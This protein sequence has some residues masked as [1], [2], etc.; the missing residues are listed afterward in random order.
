MAE[1]ARRAYPRQETKAERV[2]ALR[3][4]TASLRRD[5]EE[6]GYRPLGDGRARDAA[7]R[8]Q[9]Q[10]QPPAA[11]HAAAELHAAAAAP[12]S[13]FRRKSS[14]KN[15]LSKSLKLT[16]DHK[17]VKRPEDLAAAAA[18]RELSRTGPSNHP[19]TARLL[20]QQTATTGSRQ[21]AAAEEP[22]VKRSLPTLSLTR[23]DSHQPPFDPS[24]AFSPSHAGQ[25]DTHHKRV[26]PK[27]PSTTTIVP[28]TPRHIEVDNSFG[29]LHALRDAVPDSVHVDDVADPMSPFHFFNSLKKPADYRFCYGVRA[30]DDDPYHIELAAHQTDVQ[31][32]SSNKLY[33]TLSGSGVTQTG[34]A[35]GETSFTPLQEW[36]GEYKAFKVIASM[37]FFARYRQWSVFKHWKHMVRQTS[38]EAAKEALQANHL[39]LHPMFADPLKKVQTLCATCREQALIPVPTHTASLSHYVQQLS[40]RRKAIDDDF[41]AAF[42]EV[43]DTVLGSCREVSNTLALVRLKEAE[44]GSKDKSANYID[45]KHSEQRANATKK[46]RLATLRDL[47][48]GGE[49]RT[50]TPPALPPGAA[51]MSADS[52][53]QGRGVVHKM[54]SFL[55]LVDNMVHDALLDFAL[56]AIAGFGELVKEPG[57]DRNV[58]LCLKMLVAS[59]IVPQSTVIASRFRLRSNAPPAASAPVGKKTPSFRREPAA[60]PP[61]AA[62]PAAPAKKQAGPPAAHAAGKPNRAFQASDETSLHRTAAG[63]PV[64]AYAHVFLHPPSHLG[65]TELFQLDVSVDKSAPADFVITPGAEDFNSLVDLVVES[66]AKLCMQYQPFS[67]NEQF[68]QYTSPKESLRAAAD[69]DDESNSARSTNRDDSDDDSSTQAPSAVRVITKAPAFQRTVET[70]KARLAAAVRRAGEATGTLGPYKKLY[71][72][73]MSLVPGEIRDSDPPLEWFERAFQRMKTQEK[74]LDSMPPVMRVDIFTLNTAPL[75]AVVGPSP[76]ECMAML[77]RLLPSIFRE[78]NKKL[79]DK[80][81]TTSE[82]L[83]AP[84]DSLEAL[85]SLLRN[86]AD[87]G[88]KWPAVERRFDD[89]TAYAGFLETEDIEWAPE[90]RAFWTH[91]T[92]PVMA[93]LR[94][95]LIEVERKKDAAIVEYATVIDE[96]LKE[97]EVELLEVESRANDPAF[98]DDEADPDRAVAELDQILKDAERIRDRERLLCQYQE[99]FNLDVAHINQIAT[100]HKAANDRHKLWSSMRNWVALTQQWSETPYATIRVQEIADAAS[101]Y[102][103]YVNHLTRSLP[104]FPALLKLRTMVDEV[105]LVLPVVAALTNPA[106]HSHHKANVASIVGK[107]LSDPAC[108]L[109]DLIALRVTDLKE[110]VKSVSHAATQESSLA[111]QLAQLIRQWQ[112]HEFTLLSHKSVSQDGAPAGGSADTPTSLPSSPTSI[113]GSFAFSSSKETYIITNADP[114]FAA[115]DDAVASLSTIANSRYCVV[116]LHG[117]ATR[118]IHDLKQASATVDKWL[119]C[120]RKWLSLEAIYSNPD[121]C[122]QW[123]GEAKAFATVDRGM[124]DRMRAVAAAPYVMRAVLQSESFS[125]LDRIL[126]CLEKLDRELARN[127]N[128]KRA[129]F[130]RLHFLSD[131]DLIDIISRAKIP[132]DVS[133]HLP[134]L[135]GN[136]SSL[137]ADDSVVTGVR[138]CEGETLMLLKPIRARKEADKWLDRLEESIHGTLRKKARDAVASLLSAASLETWIDTAHEEYP[139]QMILA[140]HNVRFCH[141]VESE[142]EHAPGSGGRLHDSDGQG[143][144]ADGQEAGESGA[145]APP[146]QARDPSL[147]LRKRFELLSKAFRRE[148]DV[149]AD[150]LAGNPERTAG[151]VHSNSPEA[152]RMHSGSFPQ[153]ASNLLPAR[154]FPM[155]PLVPRNASRTPTTP[156][157]GGGNPSAAPLNTLARQSLL[158]Q[159]TAQTVHHRDIIEH[160]IASKSAA[161]AEFPWA[162]QLRA[163]YSGTATSRDLLLRQVGC[164]YAYGYEF[165]GSA[166]RLVATPLTDRIFLTISSALAQRLGALAAGPAGTGKTETIRDLARH[167]GRR[168]VVYNCSGAVTSRTVEKLLAGLCQ[169]GAWGCLDELNRVPF[170]VLSAMAHHFSA[171]RQALVAGE[172]LVEIAGDTIPIKPSFALLATM[173]TGYNARTEL[174]GNVKVLFRPVAALKTDS[175]VIARVMLHSAGFSDAEVVADRLTR[176]FEACADLLG[177]RPHYAFGLRELKMVLTAASIA[178]NDPSVTDKEDTI[179]VRCCMEGIVPRLDP[180]DSEL[181]KDVIKNLF[182]DAHLSVHSPVS[183]SIKRA[184]VNELKHEQWHEKTALEKC[185]HLHSV[186]SLRT[187]IILLGPPGSGKTVCRATLFAAINCNP[188]DMPTLTIRNAAPS[189]SILVPSPAPRPLSPSALYSTPAPRLVQAVLNPRS[190]SYNEVYGYLDPLSHTWHPGVVSQLLDE[191]ARSECESW[192]VF[193]GGVTSAWIET[194]NTVLDDTKA[195]S[196]ASGLPIRVKPEDKFLFEVD[197]VANASPATITRCCVVSFGAVSPEVTINAWSNRVLQVLVPFPTMVARASGLLTKHA[198]RALRFVER[199]A[200]AK[201][202]RASTSGVVQS[203]LS[204]FEAVAAAEDLSKHVAQGTAQRRP[205]V[206]DRTGEIVDL[207]ACY[208]LLWGVLGYLD[209]AGQEKWDEALREDLATSLV[210][211]AGPLVDQCLDLSAVRFVAW[212]ERLP[213]Y[214]PE[215]VDSVDRRKHVSLRMSVPVVDSVKHAHVIR[216]LALSGKPCL[217]SGPAGVGKT[218]ITQDALRDTGRVVPVLCSEATDA[219]RIRAVLERNLTARGDAGV[220]SASLGADFFSLSKPDGVLRPVTGQALMFL[221]DDVNLAS[222][223]GAA[224]CPFEFLRQVAETASFHTAKL[225]KKRVTGLSITACA[226]SEPSTTGLL[227]A[228]TLRHFVP[229]FIPHM[230]DDS[231]QAIT[232]TLLTTFFTHAEFSREILDLV[233]PFAQGSA[234]V[235]A[236]MQ[237]SIPPCY[238]TP[239]Y[240]FSLRS[241]KTVVQGM[242]FASAATCSTP[243][244]A[245]QLWIH[246][247]SRCF[248][249]CLLLDEHR[250]TFKTTLKGALRRVFPPEAWEGD[251]AALDAAWPVMWGDFLRPEAFG[252][253]RVY[254]AVAE[255]DKLPELFD[256]YTAD[257]FDT[258]MRLVF[259]K[260]CCVHLTRVLRML[261]FSGTHSLLLGPAFSGRQTLVRLAATMREYECFSLAAH[262]LYT[263]DNFLVDLLQIHDAA[264]LHSRD[265]VLLLADSQLHIPGVMQEINHLL[266]GYAVPNL[267]SAE[268]ESK[269]VNAIRAEG[270]QR[271]WAD[272]TFDE[273]LACYRTRARE[274]IHVVLCATPGGNFSKLCR[275]FPALTTCCQVDVVEPWPRA[276]LATIAEKLLPEEEPDL[277]GLSQKCARVHELAAHAAAAAGAANAVPVEVTP[278][279][280]FDFLSM[281]AQ[282]YADAAH[283]LESQQA[284]LAKGA[285]MMAETERVVEKM[286]ASLTAAT[287]DLRGCHEKVAAVVVETESVQAKL[288][289][290]QAETAAKEAVAAR[291]RESAEAL[292]ASAETELATVIP[293]INAAVK[294]LDALSK[295]DIIEIRSYAQPPPVVSLVTQAVLILLQETNPA[296][297]AQAKHVMNQPTFLDRLKNFDKDQIPPEASARLSPILHEREFNPENVGQTGSFA[298]KSLCLWVTAMHAYNAARIKMAPKRAAL[299]EAECILED[300]EE[301]FERAS[302]ALQAVTGELDAL[303]EIRQRAQSEKRDCEEKIGTARKRLATADVL[304]AALSDQAAAWGREAAGLG[305]RLRAA[306]KHAFLAS[307]F[308]SYAGAFNPSRR[309]GLISAWHALYDE[310]TIPRPT[311]EAAPEGHPGGPPATDARL[312]DFLSCLAGHGAVREWVVSSLPDDPVSVENALLAWNCCTER[313]NRWPL[314]VDPQEQACGWLSKLLCKDGLVTLR[315]P[316]AEAC[317]SVSVASTFAPKQQQHGGGGGSPLAGSMLL[318]SSMSPRLKSANSGILNG[319]EQPDD[320][321]AAAATS[322]TPKM[323][324]AAVP[325]PVARKPRDSRPDPGPSSRKAKAVTAFR[326]AVDHAMERGDPLLITRADSAIDPYLTPILQKKYTESYFG[327]GLCHIVLGP[328]R[329]LPYKPSFK[330]FLATDSPSTIGLPT[331]AWALCNVVNFSVTAEALEAQLLSQF[332]ATERPKW[333]EARLSA[334]SVI[335]SSKKLT[336]SYEDQTLA[337]LDKCAAGD[338]LD[339]AS[340][341]KNLQKIRQTAAFVERQIVTSDERAA[342]AQKE[343]ERYTPVARRAASL[344]FL[345]N[346]L[347]ALDPMYQYSIAAV[348]RVCCATVRARRAS[349]D[350]DQ[351]PPLDDAHVASLVTSVTS[352]VHAYISLGL[353]AAHRAAFTLCMAASTQLKEQLLAPSDWKLLF[354]PPSQATREALA[355]KLSTDI[356]FWMDTVTWQ[357]LAVLQAFDSRGNLANLSEHVSQQSVRWQKWLQSE[358]PFREQAPLPGVTDF[359]AL[360]LLLCFRPELGYAHTECYAKRVL[361]EDFASAKE[362]AA[363]VGGVLGAGPDGGESVVLFITSRDGDPYQEVLRAAKARNLRAGQVHKVSCGQGQDAALKSAWEVCKATGDWLYLENAHIAPQELLYDMVQSAQ[364]FPGVKDT[365]TPGTPRATANA[366]G[367]GFKLFLTAP[368]AGGVSPSVI[369]AA[370][371]VQRET[372]TAVRATMVRALAVEAAEVPAFFAATAQAATKAL[373]YS[374]CSLHAALLDRRRYGAQGW[375]GA[376]D[377]DDGDLR[378]ALEWIRSEAPASDIFRHTAAPDS[379][380]KEADLCGLVT[381]VSDVFYGGKLTDPWDQR[382]LGCL[383]RRFL[384]GGLEPRRPYCSVAAYSIPEGEG[385][386]DFVY[387][388]RRLPAEDAPEFSGMHPSAREARAR[389]ETDELLADALALERHMDFVPGALRRRSTLAGRR[390]SAPPPSPGLPPQPKAAGP[391]PS[392]GDDQED[393]VAALVKAVLDCLPAPI[394]F[395]EGLHPNALQREE[396]FAVKHVLKREVERY[397]ALIDTVF[398]DT[399]VLSQA[400]RGEAL[401][402]P[403]V[404]EL[405]EDFYANRVP[406]GWQAAAC[407]SLKPLADWAHDLALKV[408]FVGGWL[409]K[410][411]PDYYWLGALFSPAALRAV[412]AQQFA[413]HRRVSVADVTFTYA[414]GAAAPSLATPA[415]ERKKTVFFEAGD[416]SLRRQPSAPSRSPSGNSLQNRIGVK[417]VLLSGLYCD[418]CG[419]NVENSHLT[420]PL[421]KTRY[422][423]LPLILMRPGLKGAKAGAAL[424]LSPATRSL[425]EDAERAEKGTIDLELPVFRHRGRY[426]AGPEGARRSTFVF[427]VVLPCLEVYPLLTSSFSR[428]RRELGNKRSDG[429]L[430]VH[431]STPADDIIQYGAAIL[432]QID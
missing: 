143:L 146:A 392:P 5:A 367:L 85:A 165:L 393:R 357:K 406:A 29:W 156:L 248:S 258:R 268:E 15:G 174:P 255:P 225:A 416:S 343:R 375:S 211:A 173:N 44:G 230:S 342:A 421:P 198:V 56:D 61:A 422:Q 355:A 337:E 176:L 424:V 350:D 264:G 158:F 162:K 307:A 382:V 206:D 224:P 412:V 125:H 386:S 431:E 388:A 289:S 283:S 320:P 127:L 425:G 261:K 220:P 302:T 234:E 304:R 371:K 89:L 411:D 199:E 301:E 55:K 87:A 160:L 241:I 121:I 401:E 423:A 429:T 152:G 186:L 265:I 78:K 235:L 227:P 18:E 45:Y 274:K 428:K 202:A 281:Y 333:E 251:C 276:A 59:N 58:E 124:R 107:D 66:T 68:L 33:Y 365:K 37:P 98:A 285:G 397:N 293:D 236:T 11:A 326:Q 38:M 57:D 105:K 187:G 346:H 272:L 13:P 193:D 83:N 226:L 257:L 389:S 335:A 332:V 48:S 239:H 228:R 414:A 108:T 331:E 327:N 94:K 14:D 41:Q 243:A 247:L 43:H 155:S 286:N 314:L 103:K 396:N 178:R 86:V 294:S 73:N 407:P 242:S 315:M 376:C 182:P 49:T 296:D 205:S 368:S 360:Q 166:P 311:R 238:N 144:A 154:S 383:A 287:A 232:S 404:E 252:D 106:M 167:A 398:A 180:G 240:T 188:A 344:Y 336:L 135:F 298:C 133:V 79:L 207:V 413:E 128:E 432:T 77:S 62:A 253:D 164:A 197:S 354:S 358:N 372:A 69:L 117:K 269:R 348:K 181:L 323:Q 218:T 147:S 84:I 139:S 339:N 256:Y 271:D 262:Q 75:R 405:Y 260:E 16:R 361:G 353:T 395:E 76:K 51:S 278:A 356:P 115:I 369:R 72:N 366:A 104:A 390:A 90:D 10:P 82:Q 214:H 254:E 328:D 237:A 349:N 259:F 140:A 374:V 229:V 305:A 334:L 111:E 21:P 47:V 67:S 284:R 19:S 136:I 22:A 245:V 12:S 310:P 384:N 418:A 300:A 352:A 325:P 215:S 151:E 231:V 399:V 408:E 292:R 4:N 273:A 282:I 119:T 380:P 129:S 92:V 126:R 195:F 159:L 30:G 321:D 345:T 402:T 426:G 415:E 161:A 170:P 141:L 217:V 351:P 53:M 309:R 362:E 420:H 6:T 122:R 63:I 148:L 223:G 299:E 137:V 203:I 221:V 277:S 430:M 297:W 250:E 20:Y 275:R 50:F 291:K 114:L 387:A 359:Q 132:L 370:V 381:M 288:E 347:S 102:T 109:G 341:V 403:N 185:L 60:T 329:V 184:V 2:R 25:T 279:G 190:L 120:Q 35:P 419:W 172:K 303:V 409:R 169:S 54:T 134:K 267:F 74:E 95:E 145:A 171:C 24:E 249:D 266:C 123:P 17:L 192:F 157:L 270:H 36:M 189:N 31:I 194:L 400:L 364:A 142:Y 110:E 96:Q 377:H 363:G 93:Q 213:R 330:L 149:Y 32:A 177:D 7:V 427:S 391:V 153:A 312:T 101:K 200:S 168:C 3:P 40:I 379:G 338:I 113:G 138:S 208:A 209:A 183:Q 201:R 385:L 244:H 130:P 324:S 118:W 373:V 9:K 131:E 26:S 417:G 42:S 219:H 1:S 313:S 263:L 39:R 204:V 196:C 191:S 175:K 23:F 340:L 210:T 64:A 308:V 317:H 410:G 233:K 179:L 71:E 295:Q 81:K 112:N 52:S 222:S 318:G 150:A 306:G 80:L 97:V 246:E 27:A 394:N 34:P 290:V 212:E 46:N 316:S 163:Y 88:Q 99:L 216:L 8:T 65:Y 100:V 91:G 378:A 28:I 116:S 70:V 319:A 280:Y 322:G